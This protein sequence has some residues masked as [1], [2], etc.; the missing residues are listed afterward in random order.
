MSSLSVFKF[1]DN[2]KRMTSCVY[3]TYPQVRIVLRII[4]GI[5]YTFNIKNVTKPKS[6]NHMYTI[7]SGF[8]V[9]KTRNEIT[10]Q[11]YKVIYSKC[12]ITEMHKHCNNSCIK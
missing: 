5:K 3:L 6:M 1:G 4:F 11:L 10:L 9:G 2:V 7:V 12:N 8:I